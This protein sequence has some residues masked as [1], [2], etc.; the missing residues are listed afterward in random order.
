MTFQEV[1]AVLGSPER[2]SESPARLIA[3]WVG[4]DGEVAIVFDRNDMASAAVFSPAP[5]RGQSVIL[6]RLRAW[7]GW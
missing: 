2:G 6:S 5:A 7:L 3:T 1:K 4:E